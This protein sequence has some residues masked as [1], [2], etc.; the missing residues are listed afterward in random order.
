MTQYLKRTI[1]V[2]SKA[3]KINFNYDDFSFHFPEKSTLNIY[4]NK[5]QRK[6]KLIPRSKREIPNKGEVIKIAGTK[7]IKALI[8]A[9][10]INEI[11]ISPILIGAI[12]KFVKFL[13]HI[14]S[15][16]SILNPMLVLNKKS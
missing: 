5:L 15:K 7:P 4:N 8:R 12:N 3:K 11:I 9:V 14:S 13:L 2:V 16:K 10:N 6:N 1:I